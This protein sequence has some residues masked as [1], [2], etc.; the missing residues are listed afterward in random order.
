M[1]H[2]ISFSSPLIKLTSPSSGQSAPLCS[3][4]YVLRECLAATLKGLKSMQFASLF[5]DIRLYA[6]ILKT[7]F[8]MQQVRHVFLNKQLYYDIF[9]VWFFFFFLL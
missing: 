2:P 3:L 5:N 1:Q 7:P 4:F 8:S 6:F 9:I